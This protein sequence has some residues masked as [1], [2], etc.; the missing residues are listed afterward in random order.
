[1]RALLKNSS[2][3]KT[4][5]DCYTPP[6]VYEVIKDWVC[7]RYGIN[8]GIIVRP[9]YPGGDFENFNYPEGCLVLDNP[10][11]SILSKIK[12]FYL[13]KG[14]KFF[15][16]APSLTLFSSPDYKKICHIGVGADIV[17]ENGAVVKTSFVT[18]LDKQY[19]VFTAP[20]LYQK[21][22]AVNLKKKAK[23]LPKYSYPA[24]IITSADLQ[25]MAFYGVSFQIPVSDCV[26][27]RALDSQKQEN[28]TIFGGGLLVSPKVAAEKIIAEKIIAKKNKTIIWPLSE[29]EKKLS[30]SLDCEK[31]SK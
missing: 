2:Q 6:E 9:F 15:L 1:M 11:F 23:S 8:P 13:E 22:E 5:D 10:P 20:D 16:F 24:E 21:I 31:N 3:K 29:K 18:N 7:N 19:T 4:T 30:L 26:Y 25:K 17:Y 12:R 27:C 14:I 28:K